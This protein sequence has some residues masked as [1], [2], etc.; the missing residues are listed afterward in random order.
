MHRCI[1]VPHDIVCRPNAEPVEDSTTC[2]CSTAQAAQQTGCA[3]EAA[4]KDKACTGLG[5]LCDA[6]SGAPLCSG[7]STDCTIVEAKTSKQS[8]AGNTA[9]TTTRQVCREAFKSDCSSVPL[10]SPLASL[11]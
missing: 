3:N 10:G 7:K 8:N 4:A 1:K 9:T 11:P 6:K 2:K 5:K